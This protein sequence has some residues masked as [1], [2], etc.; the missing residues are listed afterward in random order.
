MNATIVHALSNVV[1]WV[2]PPLLGA[3]IGYLTN[4]LAIRM[5][6][7]PLRRVKIL[8]IPIP[9]TPGVIPKQRNELAESIGRMVSREL[10]T[11]E[12]F[13]RRFQDPGFRFVL[14]RGIGGAIDRIV[15]TPI[16]TIAHRVSPERLV[17]I[18]GV[19]LQRFIRRRSVRE[20]MSHALATV[21]FENR[22]F[23]V[24]AIRRYIDDAQPL[25][26]VDEEALRSV[27]DAIWPQVVSTAEH[28]IREPGVQH[29][30]D[31][32][33]KRVLAHTL[34]QL[35]G[36]QRLFVTAG[37]YDRALINKVPSIVSRTTTEIIAYLQSD[38]AQQVVVERI[39]AWV[40]E[41]QTATVAEIFSPEARRFATDLIGDLLG[42]PDRFY[43]AFKAFVMGEKISR[44]IDRATNRASQLVA[45]FFYENS[46]KSLRE[47]FPTLVR[48]R[49]YIAR[50]GAGWSAVLLQRVAPG[51]VASLNVHDVVVD[52]INDL[53]IETVEELLLGIIRRHLRWINAFGALLGAMIGGVQ[54]LL[55]VVGW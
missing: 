25:A 3:G 50:R 15:N 21:V 16:G 41:H 39:T 40:A 29:K 12:V 32:I 19:H 33:V 28:T 47:L 6:F 48:A 9:L 46:D 14:R 35:N 51:V 1:P 44:I 36:L 13:H 18:V 11:S 27:V 20:R 55:R 22:E 45:T 7:R 2:A 8:G 34:D 23:I 24:Q 42:D 31:A 4:S 30:L 53:D 26:S 5:L 17:S 49:G 10:L 54:L 38:D 43:G 52:R 37:Q